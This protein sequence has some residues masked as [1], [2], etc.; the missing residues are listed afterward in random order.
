MFL[1]LTSEKGSAGAGLLIAL[2]VV[3]LGSVYISSDQARLNRTISA[4]AHERER[5][6]VKQ[7]TQNGVNRFRSLLAER[8]LGGA[9]G[10]QPALYPADY[11]SNVWNLN[12]NGTIPSTGVNLANQNLRLTMRYADSSLSLGEAVAIMSGASQQTLQED[13]QN[14]Q[15][16]RTNY[17][18]GNSLAVESIDVR[19]TVPTADGGTAR[20]TV[21]LMLE[22]PEPKDM[23]VEISPQGTN[24]WSQNFTNLTPGY[25]DVRVVA[26]GVVLQANVGINGTP[27]PPLGV[28]QGANRQILHQ[29]RNVLAVNQEIGRF[30]Y[31][32]TSAR[33]CNPAPG[34]G[35][36][37]LHASLTKADGSLYTVSG[38]SDGAG[39]NVQVQSQAVGQRYVGLGCYWMEN[40]S[41]NYCWVPA[42]GWIGASGTIQDCKM[43]D[44][45]SGGGGMS[46]GGCY[47]WA[48]AS[49]AP[50]FPWP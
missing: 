37:T 4:D 34:D 42:P 24:A 49:D 39:I 20:E 26:S 30:T 17:K 38:I 35:L 43:L 12:R 36:Y 46:A 15:I 45:C 22:T 18:T 31:E 19:V 40:Y 10:L 8:N 33:T 28:S 16:L 9:Q 47:K 13:Q 25:Y 27:L 21:R 23:R 5:E 50:A 1:R 11:F 48:N 3:G 6:A 7:A 32:F 29:A 44:S 14:F 2:A 41:G